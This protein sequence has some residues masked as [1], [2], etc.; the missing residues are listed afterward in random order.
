MWRH[1]DAESGAGKPDRERR[2]TPEGEASARSIG[3][4]LVQ[5]GDVPDVAYCS[6]ADRARATLEIAAASGSWTT[7][8]V[9]LEDL[10]TATVEAT[11]GVIAQAPD[12]E[13]VMV[14]GHNPT[15]AELVAELTGEAV[16][17]RPATVVGIDLAIDAWAEV[18]EVRGGLAYVLRAE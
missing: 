2:L 17:L 18:T 9:L 12:L 11:L 16:G 13:R 3:A 7:E 4:L 6:A 14:V 10:Y 15:W 5:V 1:A 8:T